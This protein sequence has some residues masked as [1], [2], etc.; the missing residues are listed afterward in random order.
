MSSDLRVLGVDP[1]SVRAGWAVI[2][3]SIDRPRL[4]GCG[5]INLGPRREFADRLARL[6]EALAGVIASHRPSVA[7]VEAS[8]HGVSARSALQL[9]HARGVVLAVA[10]AAGVPVQEYTPATVKKSVTGNGRA[11]KFQVQAMVGRLVPGAG[12]VRATDVSDAIAIALCHL[13]M[14][15]LAGLAGRITR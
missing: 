15:R 13:A 8:F 1:G 12:D 14:G 3:G 10:A 9:A 4:V 11:E 6:H 5:A 2:E 7:A